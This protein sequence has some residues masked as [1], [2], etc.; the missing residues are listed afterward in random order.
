MTARVRIVDRYLAA[1]DAAALGLIHKLAAKY[2]HMLGVTELPKIVVRNNLGSRWLGRLLWRHGHQNVMEIQT[3]ALVD[4]H[5][6]ERIVAHEMAHHVEFLEI[7][8]EDLARIRIGIRPPEHGARWKEL[9]HQINSAVGDSNFITE[10]SDQA[11]VLAPESKPYVILVAPIMSGSLGYA[12]GVRLSP[13]MQAYADRYIANHEGKLIKTT[14][15]KWTNGP[16]IG[17]GFA[18]PRD[19]EGKEKLKTLYDAP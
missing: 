11:Y 13:K 16:R 9:A 2:A 15:P 12:I 8:E 18:M 19:P 5:T 3:S 1:R 17:D 7:T 14:D 4:E 6:L 10:T